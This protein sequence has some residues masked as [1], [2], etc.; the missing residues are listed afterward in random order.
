MLRNHNNNDEKK[1]ARNHAKRVAFLF[2]FFFHFNISSYVVIMRVSILKKKLNKRREQL[3]VKQK[4]AII[5][6]ASRLKKKNGRE[7]NYATLPD[8]IPSRSFRTSSNEEK[9]PHKS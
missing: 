1:A 9:K 8:I 3:E 2:S 7:K 6:S 5:Y 4:T